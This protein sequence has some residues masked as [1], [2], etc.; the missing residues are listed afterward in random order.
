MAGGE[1]GYPSARNI[2]GPSKKGSV[3]ETIE[4]P[5]PVM[6]EDCGKPLSGDELLLLKGGR[7]TELELRLKRCPAFMKTLV[8]QQGDGTLVPFPSWSILMKRRLEEIY[9]ELCNGVAHLNLHYPSTQNIDPSSNCAYF[10]AEQA[11]DVFAAHAAHAL[12]V[13]FHRLV[14]WSLM[15]RPPAELAVLFSSTSYHSIIGKSANTSYPSGI[16]PGRDFME[17]PENNALAEFNGDPRTGFNFLTGKTSTSHTS[18]LGKNEL[19]TL[20]NLTTWMRDNVAHGGSDR[21]D[22]HRWLEDRLHPMPGMHVAIANVGCHSA[23]KLMVDLARSVNIPLLHAR[24]Q[25]S[26]A[27]SGHFFN[28]THGGLIY[29]WGGNQPRILWHTDEIYAMTGEPSFPIDSNGNLMSSDQAVRAYF[30][31]RWRTPSQLAQA[32]FVYNLQTVYPDQG[33]GMSSRGVYEDRKDYGKMSGYWNKNGSSDLSA[34]MRL[35]QHY[36]ICG[37]F[38]LDLFCSQIL[39]AQLSIDINQW[40]GGFSQSQLPPMHTI[41]EYNTRAGIGVNTLGGCAA[42]NQAIMNWNNNRGSNLM[43]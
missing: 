4:I 19:E 16:Q 24:S 29:G 31:Q 17:A 32:G 12:Y 43:Q 30:D 41:N 36:E 37:A 20:A 22:Y 1:E 18:L 35:E 28:R 9:L 21:T 26:D 15:T 34:L 2:R 5:N 33:F 42:F 7:V 11:F 8:W 25:E 14:P 6:R 27:T 3:M 10:T 13:E 40:K 38:L 23:S 39:P